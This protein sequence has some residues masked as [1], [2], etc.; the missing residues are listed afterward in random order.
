MELATL[1]NLQEKQ[2]V[3]TIFYWNNYHSNLYHVK[4]ASPNRWSNLVFSPQ[5]GLCFFPH[6]KNET[7][8]YK[9]LLSLGIKKSRLLSLYFIEI[10]IIQIFTMLN[11]LLQIVG[12]LCLYL[13]VR[14]VFFSS[15]KRWDSPDLCKELLR[16]EILDISDIASIDEKIYL[17]EQ[18]IDS[19]PFGRCCWF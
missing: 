8:E 6:L 16:G 17:P 4:L 18:T 11:W 7:H 13:P 15:Y 2:T 19:F 14:F 5:F 1:R 12:V 10:I 9:A 3:I